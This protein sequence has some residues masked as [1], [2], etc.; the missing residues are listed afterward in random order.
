MR[1][2]FGNVGKLGM[3]FRRGSVRM[4]SVV[5]PVLPGTS[6]FGR[7]AA[8]WTLDGGVRAQRTL[9][10]PAVQQ[11]HGRQCQVQRHENIPRHSPNSLALGGGDHRGRPRE[12]PQAC[13]CISNGSKNTAYNPVYEIFKPCV[14]I[15]LQTQG[16]VYLH[17]IRMQLC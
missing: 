8:N 7:Q 4:V 16:V 5:L 13:R 10:E 15:Y 9:S 1:R 6:L 3:D 11:N 2:K 14:I 17:P 12:T